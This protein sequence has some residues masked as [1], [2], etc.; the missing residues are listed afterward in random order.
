MDSVSREE[1]LAVIGDFISMGHLENILAMFRQDTGLYQL[2]GELITDERYM[3]RMGMVVLFE[4]L[5]R[6]NRHDIQLALPSLLP[7]LGHEKSFVRGDIATLLGII[8]TKEAR[9]A[10][11]K[12][13]EDDDE[14]VVSVIRDILADFPAEQP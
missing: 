7:K 5:A 11:E 12:L 2:S 10:L 14:Q 8:G 4:E 9:Q 6:N 1:L 13:L 3:V